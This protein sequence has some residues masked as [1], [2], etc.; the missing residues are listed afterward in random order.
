LGDQRL[1]K[2]IYH[3]LEDQ[4]NQLMRISRELINIKAL[5]YELAEKQNIKLENENMVSELFG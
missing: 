5:I 3:K 4:Q 2:T 1:K